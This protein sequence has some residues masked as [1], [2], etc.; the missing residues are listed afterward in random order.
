VIGVKNQERILVAVK[1]IK[2]GGVVLMP[3]DTVWG[4]LCDFENP[5]A[6]KKIFYLKRTA[7][8]PIALLCSKIEDLADLGIEWPDDAKKIADKLWP[9]PLTIILKSSSR[10]VDLVAGGEGTIGIR[11]PDS[12][13]LRNMIDSF[14]KPVAATSAN[15][16]G[17]PDAAL[18]ANIPTEISSSVDFIFECDITPSGA[19]ST[20]IDCTSTRYKIIREGKISQAEIDRI[21]QSK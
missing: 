7:P 10:R 21:L 14:G 19:A 15:Y 1:T 17:R 11:I 18:F 5:S 3:T 20:V 12:K 8:R 6:I 16:S 4:L 9:G 13:V 2:K